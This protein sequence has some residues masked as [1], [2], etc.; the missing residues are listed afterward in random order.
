MVT[1]AGP[2]GQE[3]SVFSA[4]IFRAKRLGLLTRKARVVT[5]Q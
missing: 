3:A 5:Y 1:V 4:R 2:H